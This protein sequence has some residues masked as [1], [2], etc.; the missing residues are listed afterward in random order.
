ME[1][2]GIVKDQKLSQLIQQIDMKAGF[3]LPLDAAAPESDTKLDEFVDIIKRN[4]EALILSRQREQLKTESQPRGR[5][6]PTLPTWFVS[7]CHS[8]I[9]G[10]KI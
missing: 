4:L 1:L 7:F 5:G 6:L 8:L 10:R 3:I 9:R 2:A